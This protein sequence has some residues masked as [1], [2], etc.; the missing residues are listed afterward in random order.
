[1]AWVAIQEVSER[2]ILPKQDQFEDRPC[3]QEDFSALIPEIDRNFRALLDDV[4]NLPHFSIETMSTEEKSALASIVLVCG[5]H[6]AEKPWTSNFSIESSINISLMLCKLGNFSKLEE[7]I[8]NPII[9][10][11]LLN[12]L[13]PKMEP[14]S[15]KCR[16]A[17]VQCFGWVVLKIVPP[18][19]GEVLPRI[20]PANLVI[21]DDWETEYKIFGCQLMVHL[22]NNVTKAELQRQQFDDVVFD[23]L[24]KL[25]YEREAVIVVEAI[26]CIAAL[27]IKVDH[28]YNQPFEIGRY[29][30]V[31]KILLFQMEFEQGLELR[32]AYVE[33]LLLYLEAGSVSLILWSQR[34][35]RVI[36]EYL[37]IEDASG[38]ASQLLALKALLVF[39]KKTW[40]RANSNANQTLTIVL[41]LLLGVTKREPCIIMKKDVKC[42]I[43][44]L[45]K[46]CLQLLS[47]LAPVKCR[48]LLK[49]V[50]QVPAGD[51]FWS[52]LN[53]IPELK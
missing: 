2:L 29:D 36:S 25:V 35:L 15:W 1:M 24:Q 31:L 41:R 17:T 21:L 53:S 5:E 32:R 16:P 51:E 49:G 40:P 14:Y 47:S 45:I 18:T 22:I 38:G 30:N 13:C 7:L 50:E 48:E 27:V 26:K 23:I 8:L 4:N 43:L 3:C 52:V 28:K 33:S 12:S 10:K 20:F 44:D 42:Q 46:E 6:S 39:L 11:I 9:L 19:F 34:I 37:M